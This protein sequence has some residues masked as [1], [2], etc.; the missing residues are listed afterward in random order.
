MR[1]LAAVMAAVMLITAGCAGV[2]YVD[3]DSQDLEDVN[4]MSRHRF[5]KVE[6]KD[7]R[8]RA[9]HRLQAR[10]DTVSWYERDATQEKR[11]AVPTS[12]VRKIQVKK[13]AVGMGKGV[14]WGLAIGGGLGAA[15]GGTATADSEFGP[16]FGVII[17]GGLG[18][19]VGA[20]VGALT[21]L[22]MG[23]REEF[24]LE[25]VHRGEADNVLPPKASGESN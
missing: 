14:L 6:L 15:I 22:L 17:L 2:H 4:Q 16:V 19:A 9:G 24:I 10:S 20:G 21:G 18:G 7:G 1:V 3:P 23:D 8:T 25:R 11:H 13:I 5:V 12:T